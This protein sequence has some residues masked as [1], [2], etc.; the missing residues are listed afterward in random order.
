MSGQMALGERLLISVCAAART[1]DRSQRW[2]RDQLASVEAP[3]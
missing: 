2:R 3:A 1:L